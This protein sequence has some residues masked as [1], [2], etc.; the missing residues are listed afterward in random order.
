[1]SRLLLALE[2]NVPDP[3]RATTIPNQ[4]VLKGIMLKEF[5]KLIPY[6]EILDRWEGHKPSYKLTADRLFEGDEGAWEMFVRLF[7]P[8]LAPKI[9]GEPLFLADE[10]GTF[11]LNPN[12]YSEEEIQ[13]LLAYLGVPQDRHSNLLRELHEVHALHAFYTRP[14]LSLHSPS[15]RSGY[16]AN[17]AL[18]PNGN[19]NTENYNANTE[20]ENENNLENNVYGKLSS[21]N[22]RRF[23]GSTKSRKGKTK[24]LK[25]KSA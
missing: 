10:H 5:L 11:T 22:Y 25:K 13:S 18:T 1:M 6:F 8:F 15:L 24:K 23:M 17:L 14:A 9:R 12:L 20:N 2:E 3:Y 4:V 16:N 7:F 19:E 21:A